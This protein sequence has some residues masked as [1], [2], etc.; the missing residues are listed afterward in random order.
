MNGGGMAFAIGTTNLEGIALFAGLSN[1][2]I[3]VL[4]GM[5]CTRRFAIGETIVTA[6]EAGGAAYIIRDGFV[7]VHVEQ[8]D[9]RDIVL[10][11]LGPGELFGEMSLVDQLGR[12][13]SVVAHEPA[14][15]LS[16]DRAAFWSC[17]RATPAMAFNLSSILSRRLR[18]ANAHIQSLAALDVPGRIAYQLWEYAREY[19][20]PTA[21]GAVCVPFRLSQSDLAGLV[22]ASRVRVN[23]VLAALRQ[24]GLVSV[25]HGRHMVVHDSAE[26]ARRIA[27]SPPTGAVR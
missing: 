25:D 4:S 22:G 9:G 5:L 26:L 15:V 17:L 18:L 3:A 20:K 8:E 23:Q 12:S 19:G 10:A 2:Q 7:R 1:A 13:A 16:I 14:T 21:G 11:I 6:E 24:D 27:G